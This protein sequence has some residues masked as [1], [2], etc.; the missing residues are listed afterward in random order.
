MGAEVTSLQAEE[1]IVP[2]VETVVAPVAPVMEQP[3]VVP[4]P[5]VEQPVAEEKVE[6]EEVQKIVAPLDPNKQWDVRCPRC[7]KLLRV[8]EVSPYHRCPSCDKVFQIRKFETY[9][10]KD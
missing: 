1:P 9:S 4:A 7:G 3:A 2:V 6:R 10:K 5:V 8:R